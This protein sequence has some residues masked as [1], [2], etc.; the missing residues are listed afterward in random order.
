M[1]HTP[2][3]PE[4]SPSRLWCSSAF[5]AAAN[6]EC[7]DKPMD[8]EGSRIDL[9]S[10]A[11]MVVV[12]QHCLVIERSSRTA[13]VNPFT[14]DYDAMTEVPI[15][16]AAISYECPFT[17]KEYIL[18]V[19]NALHVPAMEN[20]LIPP[21]VM[22]EAGIIVNDTPKIQINDPTVDDHT[23]IFEETLFRIPLSL[24]GV[25]S[26]FP[27]SAPTTNQVDACDD[28]YLLTPNGAWNP[29]SDA[30][31]RNEENML[32]WEGNMVKKQHRKQILLS[33]IQEDTAMASA[34]MISAIESQAVDRMMP[35]EAFVSSIDSE[36]PTSTVS[37]IY[38]QDRLCSLLCERAQDSQFM[39][40]VGSTNTWIPAHMIDDDE[41]TED[42][43]SKE[44][45][46]GN[47]ASDA[48]MSL[49][50]L[51]S[52]S[53]TSWL[54]PR[55]VQVEHLSKIWW[56]DMDTAKKTLDI[57]SQNCDRKRSA[58]LSR[59]YATNDKM[60]CYKIIKE[61]FFMDTF[62]ATEKAGKSTCGNGCCQLFVTDKGF[63]YVV[64]MTK[65][66][67]VLKAI[68]Q[69][70]KEIRAPDALI[71][72]AAKA[73]T[74]KEMRSF[75]NE[76]GT[77]LRALE[78]GT[79]WANKAELY[80]GLIKEAVRKDMKSSNCPIAMWDYCL[81]RRAQINNLTAR[82]LFQLHGTNAHT[83]LTTE[84]GNISNLCQYDWYEWCFYREHTAKFPFNRE[85]LGRVLG[86][87]KGEGNEM[88]QWILKANGNVV[89]RRTLRSL[90]TAELHSPTEAKKR[91]I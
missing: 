72:D 91:T 84:E 5:I 33:E 13:I 4:V 68:K 65:E 47:D 69:F 80:I 12:G 24:W 7:A 28:V 88:A 40:S 36:S 15:V 85:V 39:I 3:K 59:N 53:M 6:D 30:Y 56:I 81:E 54:V 18:L 16:D 74:S 32:D 34:A 51:T 38:D 48:W 41:S 89:P 77:T 23:I 87:A 10:Y 2:R 52:I 46:D 57:T 79:P 78:E 8:E 20:N 73:Q 90:N 63:I 11:N 44:I 86:P 82:D 21:F 76:I 49:S 75:C 43:N 71:C 14:P 67:D 26:Y 17:G 55:N 50:M 58:D 61:F 42:D 64:L 27:T 83:A 37:P 22:R 35:T 1:S 62:Y 9:D 29:H 70:A 45:S 19:Q 60:L 66:S 31:A 25:F